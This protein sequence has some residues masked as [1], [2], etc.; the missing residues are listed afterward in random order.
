VEDAYHIPVLVNEIIRSLRAAES[1]L[2]LDA[3]LGDGGHAEAILSAMPAEGVLVGIDQDL[4]ALSRASARLQ[5]F[6]DRF[7]A[8]HG[9]FRDVRALL[10]PFSLPPFDAILADLGV[11]TLQISDPAR[12][13]MFSADGP[14]SMKMNS[15]SR[16]S[17]AEIVNEWSESD[18]A[19]IIRRYGEER[20]YRRIARA[21]V[22]ARNRKPIATTGEL[23]E[24][25]RRAAPGPQVVK[26]LART[27]QSIRMTV[28]LEEQSLLEFLPQAVSLL[29]RNGRLVVM[30][31]HSGED[32]AVKH[33]MQQQADPCTC[34]RDWPRC[35]C[36]AKPVLRIEG[37]RLMA[38]E[39]EINANPRAR[40]VRV[41]C[42]VKL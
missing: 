12:G 13:F 23:A 9:N 14:L 20:Q 41:R 22:R 25:I 21:I 15:E 18:L 24:V 37:R 35:L 8:L 10:E 7:H 38:D 39:M 28:N 4:Q 29:G 16:M 5:R 6:G 31:Y 33:F 36:G 1:R 3:T 40:S 30:T 32:R 2:V 42:A 27:F 34:P 19:Q 26:T 17:A 11:S